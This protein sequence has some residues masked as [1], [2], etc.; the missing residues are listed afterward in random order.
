M[1]LLGLSRWTLGT[2]LFFDR[3]QT[4]ENLLFLQG[5]NG[6]E[7]DQASSLTVLSPLE[8]YFTHFIPDKQHSSPLLPNHY[9]DKKPNRTIEQTK[10]LF[11]QLG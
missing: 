10:S 7:P 11:Y 4:P 1:V 8:K 6:Y 5:F 9:Q 3:P 2:C